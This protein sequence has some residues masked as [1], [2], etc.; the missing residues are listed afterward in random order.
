MEKYDL[1]RRDKDTM[2]EY[3]ENIINFIKNNNLTILEANN[4]RKSCSQTIRSDENTKYFHKEVTD[5]KFLILTANEIEREV[6]FSCCTTYPKE[7][8]LN[9]K[10]VV[11]RIPCDGLIYSFFYINDIKVVHVEPEMTGSYSKGGTAETLKKALKK[12]RPSVVISL[13]VAF[14]Y[15]MKKQQLC[16]VLIG[17][18]FFAY[19]K[20]TKIKDDELNIKKLHIVES[21]QSLLNKV[22]ATIKF[23]DKTLGMLGNKFQTHIGNILTGEYVIDS[24]AFKNLIGEPFKPFGIIGGEMEAFG[25]FTV[26]NEY[27]QRNPGLKTRGIM[28]K[29]ICDWAVGKNINIGELNLAIDDKEKLSLENNLLKNEHKL[30]NEEY[31]NC[32]QTLAMCNAC[33]VC[34]LFLISN[35]LFSDYKVCRIKKFLKKILDR[36]KWFK[37]K[38]F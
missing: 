33:A 32:F 30:S 26:I 17:R 23:E 1:D 5:I 8:T 24:C 9:E 4:L 25:M 13:G 14:G 12:V 36:I 3:T 28:I 7:F 19:D 34:K 6:L 15:D 38:H 22:K 29:G 18:Q 31:K 21:D 2:A 10:N 16:D 20:S 11:K 35:N 37:F 27:N